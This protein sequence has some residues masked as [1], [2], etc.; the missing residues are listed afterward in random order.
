MILCCE[1][2]ICCRRDLQKACHYYS[3][4]QVPPPDPR[5]QK[6][7]CITVSERIDATML[8]WIPCSFRQVPFLETLA[9]E[10]FRRRFEEGSLFGQR[11]QLSNIWNLNNPTSRSD[12]FSFYVVK[13]FLRFIELVRNFSDVCRY[14]NRWYYYFRYYDNRTWINSRMC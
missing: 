14:T 6:N 10:G 2:Y 11:R 9:E 1:S 3:H 8:F 7:F 12:L 5:C 13:S 4:H